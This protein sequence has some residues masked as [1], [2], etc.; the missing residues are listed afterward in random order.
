[1]MKEEFEWM[2]KVGQLV[3]FR[4]CELA[5]VEVTGLITRC[6]APSYVAERN[7]E[8]ALYWVLTPAGEQCFTGNQLVLV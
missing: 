6:T 3:M 1:M 5:L 4:N 7:P 8:L 2:M